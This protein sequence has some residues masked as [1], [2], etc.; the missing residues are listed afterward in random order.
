MTIRVQYQNL[1]NPQKMR[2]IQSPEENFG[3][4]K[5]KKIIPILGS[6]REMLQ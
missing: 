6:L 1:E 5:I 4:K 2:G 3:L